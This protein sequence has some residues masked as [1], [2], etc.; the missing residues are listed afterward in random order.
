MICYFVAADIINGRRYLERFQ[1]RLQ[2]K[3]GFVVVQ[4]VLRPNLTYNH[5]KPCV[6]VLYSS[7]TFDRYSCHSF[8]AAAATVED[9]YS[10]YPRYQ[11]AASKSTK[12]KDLSLF[13]IIVSSVVPVP[14]TA[15]WSRRV[16]GNNRLLNLAFR[17]GPPL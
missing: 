13:V 10:Q 5:I 2:M 4:G 8:Q 11:P 7:S 1:D 14:E 6:F 16:D 12:T 17:A 9:A 15:G 3:F